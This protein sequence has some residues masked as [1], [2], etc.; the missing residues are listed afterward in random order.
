MNLKYEKIQDELQKK[1]FTKDQ[2]EIVINTLKFLSEEQNKKTSETLR[3]KSKC[4][5]KV[6]RPKFNKPLFFKQI[7]IFQE[8]GYIDLFTATKM[9]NISKSTFFKYKLK[10]NI[11][12][13][14]LKSKMYI[15]PNEKQIELYNKYSKTFIDQWCYL[16]RVKLKKNLLED[17]K[18]ECK[19]AIY[20]KLPRFND[21]FE[22]F[23][24]NTCYEV[25][26]EFSYKN[27]D[28]YKEHFTDFDDRKN[29]NI[30]YNN[31]KKGSN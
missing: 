23:C 3:N 19:L 8:L 11:T 1:N 5:L 12:N 16:N 10:E 7:C 14:D 22:R 27:S 28:L 9:L 4:G 21:S 29:H 17:F 15:K 25:Y 2:I 26:E 6:G 30:M 31:Y 13:N 18:T 24:K 20:L